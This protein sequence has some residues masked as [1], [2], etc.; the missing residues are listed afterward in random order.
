[1]LKYR[2]KKGSTGVIMKKNN[3]DN[4]NN[5]MT[6]ILEKIKKASSEERQLY[7]NLHEIYSIYNIVKEKY[8]A[9]KEES[10]QTYDVDYNTSKALDEFEERI[11]TINKNTGN[12]V[13]LTQRTRIL[14][15]LNS[16]GRYVLKNIVSIPENIRNIILKD[17]NELNSILKENDLNDDDY[18]TIEYF[19]EK[20]SIIQAYLGMKIKFWN[21]AVGA[22][23]KII[24]LTSKE[25]KTKLRSRW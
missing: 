9:N 17:I 8:K 5:D 22:Y 15:E 25:T 11:Y 21:A 4:N 7:I 23:E 24:G 13:V 1:M 19:K 18:E 3:N 16:I 12:K 10:H 20:I 14:L 2:G 6:L